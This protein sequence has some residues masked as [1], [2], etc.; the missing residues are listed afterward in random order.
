MAFKRWKKDPKF[1]KNVIIGIF[2]FLLFSGY[3]GNDELQ[4]TWPAPDV[5][6]QYNTWSQN[7]GLSFLTSDNIQTCITKECAI[8]VWNPNKIDLGTAQICVA[9]VEAGHYTREPAYCK[10][11]ESNEL[12][13]ASKVFY[14]GDILGSCYKCKSEGEGNIKIVE[15]KSWEKP[16]A[17]VLDS[18]WKSNG[19]D[20]CSTKAYMV[21]GFAVFAVLAVL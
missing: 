18:I 3:L 20:D 5:C 7:F 15:C 19:I 1:R 8:E 14:C 13:F 17:G 11:G 12:D 9:G 6:S 2:I 21:I 16:I 4:A 10:S